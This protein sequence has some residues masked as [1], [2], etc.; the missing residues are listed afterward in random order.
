[1]NDLWDALIDTAAKA[2]QK[3]TGHAQF[4]R[5]R[6]SLRCKT[7]GRQGHTHAVT[8]RLSVFDPEQQVGSLSVKP[9]VQVLRAEEF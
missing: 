9:R 8:V 3:R 1:M 4:E 6:D 2:H 5:G 7:C